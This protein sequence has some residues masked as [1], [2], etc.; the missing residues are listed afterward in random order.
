MFISKDKVCEGTKWHTRVGPKDPAS[1]PYFPMGQ[2]AIEVFSEADGLKVA[3]KTLTPNFKT[4]LSRI[5]GGEW[6]ES[7]DAI[8]WKVR[9]G[10]NRL[11]VKTINKFGVEGPVSLV[12]VDVEAVGIQKVEVGKNRELRVNGKPFFPLMSW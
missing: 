8:G 7:G 3:L 10:G 2:A 5:N 12:V 9:D 11:E 1:E 6:K 4:Y